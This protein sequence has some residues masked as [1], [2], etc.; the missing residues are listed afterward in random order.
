M[1]KR[2]SV[3]WARVRA[4]Y[5][6]RGQPVRLLARR[7]KIS[8]STIYRRIRDYEWRM[9]AADMPE[10]QST[11]EPEPQEDSVSAS[12][13][14]RLYRTIDRKLAQLEARLE[15]D[16]SMTIA[17]HEREARAIGQLIRNV[18]KIAGLQPAP[19]QSGRRSDRAVIPD[20]AGESDAEQIRRE[21]ADRILR[22]RE[23]KRTEPR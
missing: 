20:P 11:N 13:L 22:F 12:L 8:P 17:D 5:E 4:A 15:S 23:I 18:E 9:P 14:R 6:T 19:T 1:P 21:L 7:Y 3:N 2:A 10:L 16:E